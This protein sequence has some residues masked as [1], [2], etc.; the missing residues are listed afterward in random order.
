M[1]VDM[2]S[3]GY[4]HWESILLV[5]KQELVCVILLVALLEKFLASDRVHI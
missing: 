2:S 5:Q 1:V 4:I 3:L